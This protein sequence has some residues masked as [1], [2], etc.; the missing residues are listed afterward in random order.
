MNA[1]ALPQQKTEAWFSVSALNRMTNLGM[2]VSVKIQKGSENGVALTKFRFIQQRLLQSSAQSEHWHSL[3]FTLYNGLSVP[4]RF[5]SKVPTRLHAQ[6][7]LEHRGEGAGTAVAE[8]FCNPRNWHAVGQ[9]AKCFDQPRLLSPLPKT[10]AGFTLKLPR[11]CAT[12]GGL[13][14]GQRFQRFAAVRVGN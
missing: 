10:H 11:K 1:R 12:A 8:L 4:D 3:C 7:A 5:R 6:R 9:V 13:L 2:P 14:L